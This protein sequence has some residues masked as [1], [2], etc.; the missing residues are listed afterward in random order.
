MGL[1]YEGWVKVGDKYALG[2]GLSVPRVSPFLESAAGYGGQIKTP[3][4]EM[5]LG[6]PFNF[7]YDVFDGNVS[8]EADFDF[9]KD[10]LTGWLLDR[11][12]SKEVLFS[13]RNSNEQKHDAV[14]FSNITI[15]SSMDA[16]LDGSIQFVSLN[17][18]TYTYGDFDPTKMGNV[19]GGTALCPDV[20]FP[21]QLNPGSLNKSPI[22][23]WR[24]KVSLDS[25]DYR[26]TTW[27]MNFSQDVVKFFACEHNT[28][29]QAPKYLAVGPMMVVFSGSYIY[30][31]FLPDSITG[32]SKLIVTVGDPSSPGNF[33]KMNLKRCYFNTHQDDLQPPD[34]ITSLDV[35]YTVYEIERTT[36]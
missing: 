31:D 6:L 7:D 8:V 27:T 9:Y 20:G 36:I 2:T 25:T 1:G 30:D 11:Q 3:V 4:E 17:R 28:S 34:G 12:A 26:F 29:A 24:T 21:K 23:F 10:V 33:V 5:G 22:P 15:T 32:T 14:W 18:N 35:E 19:S 16:A 13:T